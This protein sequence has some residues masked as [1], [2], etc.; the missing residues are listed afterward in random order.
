MS[1][2][3]GQTDEGA[4]GRKCP[5]WVSWLLVLSLAVNLLIAGAV[6]TAAWRHRHWDGGHER[7][8]VFG[9]VRSLDK[10]RR[11][12]ILAAARAE[13]GKLRPVWRELSGARRNVAAVLATQPFDQTKFDAAYGAL[14]SAEV[15]SR[16]SALQFFGRLVVQLNESERARLGKWLE[17]S[18]ERRSKRWRH[19]HGNRDDAQSK[20]AQGKALD[21]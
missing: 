4:G 15:E 3:L 9:F 20:D 16:K 12:E 1:E 11:H 7:S 13:R 6:G 21:K 8:N 5:R 2:A 18:E 10:E 14:I 17:R 19:R